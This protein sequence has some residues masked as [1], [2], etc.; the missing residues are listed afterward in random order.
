MDTFKTRVANMKFRACGVGITDNKN[1]VPKGVMCTD[2]NFVGDKC[3]DTDA[4]IETTVC[5]QWTDRDNNLW[6]ILN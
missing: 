2:V 1:T 4:A 6:V 5:L 3:E